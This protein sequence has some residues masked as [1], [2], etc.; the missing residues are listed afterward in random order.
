[1]VF[2]EPSGR[3][4]LGRGAVE[5]LIAALFAGVVEEGKGRITASDV[6]FLDVALTGGSSG[7]FRGLDRGTVE[8]LEVEEEFF[9][10][11]LSTVL[12]GSAVPGGFPGVGV[13][14]VSDVFPN[15]SE[16]CLTG[17]LGV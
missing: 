3:F 11:N 1:M 7:I 17:D 13:I 4:C 5:T 8:E 12:L 16:E 14:I 9:M 6:A 2:S 15:L 10:S